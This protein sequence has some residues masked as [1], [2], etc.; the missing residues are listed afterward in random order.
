MDTLLDQLKTDHPSLLFKASSDF[1][2]SPREQTVYYTEKATDA[3]HWNWTLLHEISHGL[4]G[5]KTFTSDFEL[6]QLELAA[7]VQAKALAAHYGIEID[8]DHIEDC[9]DTYRDWLHKRSLCPGCAVKS[10]QKAP[11]VYACLNCAQEWHVSSNRLCRAYRACK[12]V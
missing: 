11:G 12:E 8:E 1:Y 2:W 10:L 3:Q 4:L 7:W 5:H 6:L 9:L